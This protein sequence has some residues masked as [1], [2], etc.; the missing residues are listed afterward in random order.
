[1]KSSLPTSSG[2]APLGPERSEFR[3]VVHLCLLVVP[4][5]LVGWLWWRVG[6][7]TTGDELLGAAALVLLVAAVALPL[8]LVWIIHNVRIFRRKGPRTGS[9][10]SQM[11]YR[12]DWTGRPVEADWPAVRAAAAVAVTFTAQGKVFVA[13]EVAAP[14]A[15]KPTTGVI[16][17]AAAAEDLIAEVGV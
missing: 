1:M 9:A 2:I 10:G 17:G 13:E 3:D 15:D 14:R 7:T 6:Q 12:T 16:P 11:E 8:N 5:A 4:W